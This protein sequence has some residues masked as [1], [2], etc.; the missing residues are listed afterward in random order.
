[1]D[2]ASVAFV[3]GG[4]NVIDDK[5]FTTFNVLICPLPLCP[6]LC[7]WPVLLNHRLR[8]VSIEQDC[9][10]LFAINAI[11]STSSCCNGVSR[12]S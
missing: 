7:F 10:V 11:R 2:L 5:S 12:Y 8:K 3:L 9:L 1:M 6:W 4:Y